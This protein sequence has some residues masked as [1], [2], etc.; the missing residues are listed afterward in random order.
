MRDKNTPTKDRL[1]DAAKAWVL[2]NLKPGDT[3]VIAEI[4]GLKA[5]TVKKNLRYRPGA[6]SVLSNRCWVVAHSYLRMR[7]TLKTTMS[8]QAA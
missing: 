2:K 6:R 3:T 5:D 7:A 4:A 1:G 8:T